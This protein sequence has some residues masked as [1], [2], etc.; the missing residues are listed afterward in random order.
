[1]VELQRTGGPCSSAPARPVPQPPVPRM[2]LLARWVSARSCLRAR[3]LLP[4]F[5]TQ[6]STRTSP[7][8]QKS[9][10]TNPHTNSVKLCDFGCARHWETQRAPS[11]AR[12]GRLHTFVG[13]PAYMSPQVCVRVFIVVCVCVFISVCV[14]VCVCVCVSVASFACVSAA[15]RCALAGCWP[16]LRAHPRLPPRPGVVRC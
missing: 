10:H 13:T 1:M 12:M 3:S 16:T 6:R 11:K 8:P 4:S 7:P 9:N 5:E 2:L 15:S 14:C